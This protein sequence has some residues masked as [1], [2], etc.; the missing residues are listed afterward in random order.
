LDRQSLVET[1]GLIVVGLLLGMGLEQLADPD[2]AET[3]PASEDRVELDAE[4]MEAAVKEALG[5]P[6]RL[7]RGRALGRAFASLDFENSAAAKGALSASLGSID[8]CEIGPFTDALARIDPALALEESV[9][10]MDPPM[11]Q[12]G[13]NRAS[14][15]WALGG[16]GLAAEHAIRAIPDPDIHY[17]GHMGVVRGMVERGDT[18]AADRLLTRMPLE[19]RGF[20]VASIVSWLLASEGPDAVFA[21]AEAMPEDAAPQ[22]KAYSMNLA[23]V[24]VARFDPVR[25]AAWFEAQ[26]T[27]EENA[28]SLTLLLQ[29]WAFTDPDSM[30]DW[31]WARPI[32]PEVQQAFRDTVLNWRVRDPQVVRAWL[33]KQNSAVLQQMGQKALQ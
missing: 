18:A 28:P 6:T 3:L 10:W 14:Y 15:H 22:L 12:L 32:T 30:L 31:V 29:A 25:A 23:L 11:R 5:I 8:N 19:R 16:E 13:V 24:Q 2:A 21:W 27:D 33:R 17:L 1:A 20:L 26:P 9:G 4:A 7:E